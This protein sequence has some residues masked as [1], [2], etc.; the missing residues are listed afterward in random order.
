[1]ENRRPFR[2]RMSLG[3]PVSHTP[4]YTFR[5]VTTAFPCAGTCSVVPRDGGRSATRSDSPPTNRLKRLN[6]AVASTTSR[7]PTTTAEPA[8]M[9]STRRSGSPRSSNV[10]NPTSTMKR[11]TWSTNPTR[12]S[13]SH[14]PVAAATD[15]AAAARRK[16][17]ASTVTGHRLTRRITSDLV[18][19]GSLAPASVAT[20]AVTARAHRV[21]TWGTATDVMVSS[22]G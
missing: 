2:W 6:T 13:T 15:S 11:S 7:V 3:T 17:K 9:A 19:A 14:A 5:P 4:T 21:S 10:S 18:S 8:P 1:M 12:L 22:L 20:E 16:T